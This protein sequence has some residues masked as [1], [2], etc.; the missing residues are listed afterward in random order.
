MHENILYSSGNI[1][2]AK[3]CSLLHRGT[4]GRFMR[5]EETVEDH[6]FCINIL[7][8]SSLSFVSKGVINPLRSKFIGRFRKIYDVNFVYNS[9]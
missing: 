5:I 8:N 1:E 3:L 2:K 6:I 7:E 9:R 4:S